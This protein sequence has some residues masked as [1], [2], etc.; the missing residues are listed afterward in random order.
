LRRYLG[1]CGVNRRQRDLP[2]LDLLRPIDMPISVLARCLPFGSSVQ[3]WF[4][5]LHGTFISG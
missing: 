3:N 2:Q 4:Q 5:R 1:L